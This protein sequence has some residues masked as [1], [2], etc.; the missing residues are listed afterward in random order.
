MN[1]TITILETLIAEQGL[2]LR[3]EDTLSDIVQITDRYLQAGW[4][5]A[6]EFATQLEGIFR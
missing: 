5:R 2:D 3:S 1:D 4:P 6:F